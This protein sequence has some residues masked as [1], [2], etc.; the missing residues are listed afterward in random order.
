MGWFG[1]KAPLRFRRNLTQTLKF[2]RSAMNRSTAGGFFRVGERN[3]LRFT[4]GNRP[5]ATES[6]CRLGRQL[7]T[8]LRPSQNRGDLPFRNP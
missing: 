1:S 7:Y 4:G 2:R 8:F 5:K 6:L 3:L